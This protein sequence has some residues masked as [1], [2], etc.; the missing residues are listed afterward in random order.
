MMTSSDTSPVYLDKLRVYPFPNV[1]SLMDFIAGR[2][3]ILVAVNAE[4][5]MNA[6]DELVE[7]INNNIGY[8]D[9]SGAVLACKQK[10][11][12]ATR[13]PGCEL[14][15]EIIKNM[16]PAASFYLV[17]STQSVIDTTVSKLKDVFPGINILGWRNG[18]ID[19]EEEREMVISEVEALRPDVVFVAMG[20][21]RQEILMADMQKRHKA[22]Y[23]GLGG[24]F[25]VFVGA[26]KRAPL[27]WQRH[28]C[29]FLYRLLIRPKRLFRNTA[30][31]RL[32]IR[33]LLKKYA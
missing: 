18:F 25:D 26:Q 11:I 32:A 10:G 31:I 1:V 33:L 14:W 6:S 9:G 19:S 8:C 30:Q 23:Q 7:I 21:P 3:G 16:Y 13:I 24:S 28:N 12:T 22:I 2:K 29:E 5:M 17:G 15:L 4:K 27:W 20:S